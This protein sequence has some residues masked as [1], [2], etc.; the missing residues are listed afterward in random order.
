MIRTAV[1]MAAGNGTRFG[2]LTSKMPKGFIKFKGI[3]MVE[4][5]IKNLLSAGIEKVIIGTGYHREWYDSLREKFPQIITAF[6]PDYADT[7]SM[8]TLARC[9]NDI[10]EEDFL[11]LESDI[12]YDKEAIV[13]IMNDNR[14]DIMLV[15]PVT[16]FQDQY[17]IFSNK[18]LTLSCCSTNKEDIVKKN[19]VEPIGELVG[20]HK[21]SKSFYNKILEHYTNLINKNTSSNSYNP[22]KRGYEFYIEDAAKEVPLGLLLMPNLQWYEIDD[23]KDL[24]YAENHLNI[25]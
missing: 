17:Y 24:E 18:D 9:K 23:E 16:K 2:T 1:I 13:S 12:I 10:G 21:I 7:N 11:L 3:P 22:R 4:R 8:E 6:S 19:G 20:I 25:F 14:S 15:A 5:S